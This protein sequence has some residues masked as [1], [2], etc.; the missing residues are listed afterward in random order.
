MKKSVTISRSF[1]GIILYCNAHLSTEISDSTVAVLGK[2]AASPPT[3]FMRELNLLAR[4]GID[5]DSLNEVVV[6]KAS[7]AT[8]S[9]SSATLLY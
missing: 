7:I 5:Q 6:F 2:G 3:K 8:F 4:R 1:H 9:V